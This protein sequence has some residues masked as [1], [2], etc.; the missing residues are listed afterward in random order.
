VNVELASLFSQFG[1]DRVRGR[2][3]RLNQVIAALSFPPVLLAMATAPLLLAAWLS[4]APPNSTAVL[5]ALAGAYLLNVSTGVGYGVAVAAGQPGVV[6]K[7][8]VGAMVANI[9]L[10][11]SLAPLFGIWG[12][13]GG[14]VLALSAGA[15]AQ[16]VLVH[17]RY[18]LPASSYLGAI[19]PALRT[20]VILATPVAVI[21][22]AH[23]VH[24]RGA[25]AVMFVALSLAYLGA[26]MTWALRAGRLPPTLTSRLPRVAWLRP[27]A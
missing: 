2:Y 10:T 20:Y 14:T 23:V 5:V 24:G 8:A 3:L 16:V 13:L 21:S 4:H 18:H 11:A 9:V 26:C 22:Y 19:A 6:A 17:R 12:V 27:S 1:L 15:I 25:Q 7:S